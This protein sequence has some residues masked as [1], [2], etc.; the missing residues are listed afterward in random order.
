MLN[1]A[2]SK[3]HKV[4]L[5]ALAQDPVSEWCSACGRK[6]GRGEGVLKIGVPNENRCNILACYKQDVIDR[7]ASEV[8][9]ISGGEL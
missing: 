6:F 8:D 1:R 7:I 3:A 9:G 2:S 5:A 4:S